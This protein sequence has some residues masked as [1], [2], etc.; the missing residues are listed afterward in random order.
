M[1]GI[2]EQAVWED[3]HPNKNKK[4]NT[5]KKWKKKRSKR[6]TKRNIRTS[7]T[8]RYEYVTAASKD[9]NNTLA[10]TDTNVYKMR[11]TQL[12][13]CS[14]SQLFWTALINSICT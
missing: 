13:T 2:R 9:T 6:Q 4:G 11:V 5:K 14:I 3:E 10:D 8:L 1:A 7:H 12:I